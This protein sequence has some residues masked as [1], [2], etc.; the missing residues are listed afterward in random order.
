[1][2]SKKCP[3]EKSSRAFA[4]VRKMYCFWVFVRFGERKLARKRL[5]LGYSQLFLKKFF[6]QGRQ[7]GG[8][9]IL[10]QMRKQGRY[11]RKPGEQN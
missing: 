2:I 9:Q 8:R 6:G 1:L 11:N 3:A 7:E 5:F 10:P 4:F